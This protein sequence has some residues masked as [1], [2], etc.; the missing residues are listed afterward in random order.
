MSRTLAEITDE[1]LRL[2][3]DE[4]L[5]LARTLLEQSEAIGDVDAEA[6]WEEEIEC[7][8]LRGAWH[9]YITPCTTRVKP[10]AQGKVCMITFEMP[11]IL[12]G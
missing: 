1:A 10:V 11:A 7:L 8:S 12:V 3:Q 5:R 9:D 6:A 4:Q 2:S